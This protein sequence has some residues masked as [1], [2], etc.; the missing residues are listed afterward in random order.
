MIES[1]HFD[2]H[3]CAFVVDYHARQDRGKPAD[4]GG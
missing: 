1:D 3:F 2:D 4:E